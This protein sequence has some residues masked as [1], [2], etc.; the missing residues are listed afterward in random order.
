MKNPYEHD[1]LEDEVRVGRTGQGIALVVFLLFL[2]VPAASLIV[3]SLRPKANVAP[4]SSLRDRLIAWEK[5]AKTLPLFEQWRR[6]DQFR[7]TAGLG[8]GNAK[9]FSGENGWLYYR[10]DLE[11]ITGKGPDHLEPPSVAR[12]KAAKAWQPPLPVIRDFAAQLAERDI[13]LVF[14]PVPTKPMLCRK[15]LGLDQGTS[16]PP[17]WSRVANDLAA[18]GIGFVDLFP[19]IAARGPDQE[20]FLKQ[21]THWTPGTMEAAAREVAARVSPEVALTVPRFEAIQRKGPGDLVG[22]L[23]FENGEKPIFGPEEV[24][25]RKP[26]VPPVEADGDVVLLGDSF[27]NVFEDPSL[28]F[29][30]ADETTIG[31]GFASHFAAA[32]GRPVQTIAINGGGATAVREAFARLPAARLAGVKTVVWVLSSRDVLLPEIPARRAGIEWRSVTLP[33]AET[34]PVV[35]TS[36]AARELVGALVERSR[37]EDPTQTPYAEAVFSTVFKADDG[38]EHLVFFWGF[39]KRQLEPAAGLEVGRRYRLKV[40][41]F[42]KDAAAHR[43]TRLDDLFRPDLEPVFAESFEPLP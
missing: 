11:A 33:K 7:M 14:V 25:L 4:P 23:D 27:V 1:W 9:V 34:T 43:A 26:S 42:E 32:L 22:M 29:G 21:D 2:V 3:P 41:P 19:V 20:R 40:M 38:S 8:T 30:E 12:E 36:I 24:E 18:A 31:A 17:A 37:I 39:R 16:I 5:S 35:A 13:R 6:R 28:G 10:P 15:G